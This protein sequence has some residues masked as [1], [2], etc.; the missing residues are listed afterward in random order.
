MCE[1]VGKLRLLG[2]QKRQFEAVLI[3]PVALANMTVSHPDARF[4][5]RDP[6]A[7]KLQAQ[8]ARGL[9]WGEAPRVDSSGNWYLPSG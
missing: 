2:I 7:L 4:S 9:K 8:I 1:F 3:N 5:L 6:G